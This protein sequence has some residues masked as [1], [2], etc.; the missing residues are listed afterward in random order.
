MSKVYDPIL[1]CV[2]GDRVNGEL[3]IHDKYKGKTS[4]ES[5]AKKEPE[6]KAPSK[7]DILKERCDELGIKYKTRASVADLEALLEEVE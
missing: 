2:V 1:K 7:K 6:D 4:F 3:T 5:K